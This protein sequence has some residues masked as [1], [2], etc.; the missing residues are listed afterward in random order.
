MVPQKLLEKHYLE[1][2]T[3][4]NDRIKDRE[5]AK[6]SIV[7]QVLS[8]MNFKIRNENIKIVVLGASDERYISVHRRIFEEILRCSIDIVT[9]DIDT[10]HLGGE[11]KTVISH[12]VTK[13]FPNVFYDIVFSHEL[14]KFLSPNER[15]AVIRN[16]YEAI[17]DGGI[18]MHVLHEPSIKGTSELRPWQN[19]VD[20]NDLIKKLKDIGIF[21]TKLEFDSDTDIDWARKTTVIV[22]SKIE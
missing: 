11:S 5:R 18:A 15:L 9:L 8:K 22:L 10:K 21:A 17:G 3:R 2:S 14:M 1:Y 20:P 13:P 19:R 7:R 4:S 6:K 16:S 12:D